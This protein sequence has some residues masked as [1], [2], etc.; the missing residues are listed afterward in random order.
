MYYPVLLFILTFM[1]RKSITPKQWVV[2]LIVIVITSSLL[3]VNPPAMLKER[4]QTAVTEFNYFK[5]NNTVSGEGDSVGLRLQ[6][7][8]DSIKMFAGSP[9]LGVGI[10]N[11]E[12]QSKLLISEGKPSSHGKVFGHAHNIFFNALA[13]TGLVGFLGLIILVFLLPITFFIKTWR[14]ANSAELKFYSLAGII[15]ISSFIVFG[16]TEAWLSRNPLVK[17]YLIIIVFLM[18]HIMIQDRKSPIKM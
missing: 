3:L 1:Y 7:W 6:M 2:G 15:L 17:T 18:S 16:L 14:N 8:Q 10:N 4:I 9:I 11:F 13:T 12:S 5:N